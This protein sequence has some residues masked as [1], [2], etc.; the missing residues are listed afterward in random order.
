M[1]PMPPQIPHIQWK[2][3]QV[4]FEWLGIFN[5]KKGASLHQEI[6]SPYWIAGWVREGTLSVRAR[7]YHVKAQAG[8]WIFRQPS[9]MK[10]D[11]THETNCLWIAFSI[12]WQGEGRMLVPPH[13]VLWKSNRQEAME[14]KALRLLQA[15]QLHDP[16]GEANY[17][18]QTRRTSMFAYL[19]CQHLFYDW[20]KSWETVQRQYDMGWYHAKN[21]DEK[22]AATIR[23]MEALPLD[24]EIR[25]TKIARSLGISVGHLIYLFQQQLGMPPKAYRM[26]QKLQRALVELQTTPDEIKEIA[27]RFGCTPTWFG[28]WIKRETGKTPLQLRRE[29]RITSQEKGN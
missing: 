2:L 26:K 11:A 13:N 21:L 19:D 28:I 7:K 23:Y 4:H 20:L 29:A 17:Y 8:D 12:Y 15:V 22:V 16:T 3:L 25:V 27:H 6:H 1:D 14:N 10:L 9:Q 18:S 5:G 24:Q